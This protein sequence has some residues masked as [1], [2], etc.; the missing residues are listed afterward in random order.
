[1]L[2]NALFP[3]VK[4]DPFSSKII[5]FVKSAN[6]TKNHHFS[7]NCLLKFWIGQE[8][9]TK[10]LLFEA[11][12]QVINFVFDK[13]NLIRISCIIFKDDIDR[14]KLLLKLGFENEGMRKKFKKHKYTGEF[15]DVK[16]FGWVKEELS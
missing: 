15:I 4:L 6:F 1:M 2:N 8:F 16:C 13:L 3:H 10:L 5:F 14:E 7:K 11:L 12:E 9:S